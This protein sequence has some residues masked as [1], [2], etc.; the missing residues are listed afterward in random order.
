MYQTY[1]SIDTLYRVNANWFYFIKRFEK[2]QEKTTCPFQQTNESSEQ[3][4]MKLCL[5]I[6]E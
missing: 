1:A 5:I 2:R 6:N 3:D 4:I